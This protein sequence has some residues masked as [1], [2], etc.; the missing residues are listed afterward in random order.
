MTARANIATN[1]IP[2]LLSSKLNG[3]RRVR[4]GFFTREGGLSGDIFSS[5][6]VGLASGDDRGKVIDNRA[7]IAESF[8]QKSARLVMCTQVHGDTVHWLNEPW[9]P[10]YHPDGDAMVTD[11]P[12]IILGVQT[13]DCCPILLSSDNGQVIGA[14]HAGWKGAL[15]GVIQNTV[16][17]MRE[18]GAGAIQAAIGPAIEQ[19]FYEVRDDFKDVFLAQD[20]RNAS[21]FIEAPKPGH[22]Y[23]DLKGYC[24]L[25]C[26]EAD[27]EVDVMTH[28]TYEEQEVLF[29]CRRSLHQQEKEFGRQLSCIMK[30]D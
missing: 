19:K 18:R 14:I 5:L 7:L 6:N 1:G 2:S 25:L 13:A 23:F 12:N 26:E 9:G 10:M 30:Q 27:V 21:F 11:Q 20:K 8:G 17:L 22:A 3:V 28:D 16:A 4:H 29:S 15:T 24:Q